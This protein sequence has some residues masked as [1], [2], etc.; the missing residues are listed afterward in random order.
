M[1]SSLAGLADLFYSE[2]LWFLGPAKVEALSQLGDPSN[3]VFKFKA[4]GAPAS[5][6]Y[7]LP[8]DV[9]FLLE[10]RQKWNQLMERLE[11]ETY[12]AD[13]PDRRKACTVSKIV[14]TYDAVL[15]DRLNL[16]FHCCSYSHYR[17]FI[18]HVAPRT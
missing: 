3:A 2:T 18:S 5:M 7:I 15:C 16:V 8:F 10:L 11:A 13:Y 17:H 1:A 14:V 4:N 6:T 12:F 9:D